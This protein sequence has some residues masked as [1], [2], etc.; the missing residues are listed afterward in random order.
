MTDI[1][2]E[3]HTA[4]QGKYDYLR[5]GPVDISMEKKKANVVFLVPEDVYDY[6]LNSDDIKEI[7]DAVKRSLK[8]YSV[9]CRFEKL[10]LTDESVRSALVEY[11][12]K[13]F[14]LIAA[15][16]DLSS[17][18]VEVNENLCLA[19]SVRKNIREYMDRVDFDKKLK[20]FFYA[21]FAV[22]LVLSYTMQED[23]PTAS[24]PETRAKAGRYGKTVEV[25]DKVL[26]VG[27][28]SDLHGA[29]VHISTLRG[30]GEDAICCGKISFLQFKKRDESKKENYKRFFK[31]YY[32]FTI[33][34]TTGFLN[35][36]LNTDEE[37]S[38]LQNGAEVVCKG[39]VNTREESLNFSMYVKS[40]ATCKIPFAVIEE[41]TKPLDP[42]EAYT[43]LFPQEY[44]E[45]S[46]DQLGFDFLA[47]PERHVANTHPAAVV[48]VVRSLKT[49]RL[50]VPY[51]IALCEVE[52]GTI[53]R[54][55]HSYLKVAFTD[56][57]ET[58][59]FANKKG[60][61]SPRLSTVIPD[62]VKFTAGKL[63]V[64][65]NPSAALDLLNLTAKPLRYFFAN[66]VHVLHAS[67]VKD[68]KGRK[69]NALEEAL[70]LAHAY[71]SE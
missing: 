34:D 37:I 29:A 10:V 31:Y 42:P 68:E 52:G 35:V 64:G 28:L 56:D 9:Y 33:S 3:L 70:A 43:V 40:I 4:F 38:F 21:K 22:T 5:L 27:K 66:D 63:V 58:A 1:L 51:E 16:V 45:V 23:D 71:L 32:T 47:R 20:E 53:S 15:N 6:S 67:L 36:F 25:E 61:A 49:E 8:G 54:Y 41:Q 14:P 46:Y 50:F 11:M 26:L 18:K 62:L 55:M 13:Y 65:L 24:L 39:R 30:E 69:G 12:S 44:H 59:A 17:L 7:K 57:S 60:Y 2:S 19:F 48:L